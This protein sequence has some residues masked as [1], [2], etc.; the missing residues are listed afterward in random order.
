MVGFGICVR[1]KTPMT[2][3]LPIEKFANFC[4]TWTWLL[5]WLHEHTELQDKLTLHLVYDLNI[6]IVSGRYNRKNT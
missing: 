3:L 5:D 1:A 2:L 6:P 4:R